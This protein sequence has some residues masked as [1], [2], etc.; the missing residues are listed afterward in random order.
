LHPFLVGARKGVAKHVQSVAF[1]GAAAYEDQVAEPVDYLW[2]GYLEASHLATIAGPSGVGK[3]TLAFLLAAALANPTHQRV[4][5][6]GRE[7]TPIPDGKC[8]CILEEENGRRS[9][10]TNLRWS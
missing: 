2:N 7:V 5:L 9:T 8:V 10:A 6:L 3:S 1:L 4:R